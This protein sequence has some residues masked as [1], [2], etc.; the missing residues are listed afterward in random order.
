MRFDIYFTEQAEEE[1]SHIKFNPLY[2]G[3]HKQIKKTLIYLSENPRHKS[4]N[5]HKH[6]EKSKEYDF[7]VFEAYAQNNTPGAY[8]IFFCYLKNKSITILTISPHP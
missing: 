4:L 2:K 1:Y 8:R 5:T 6:Y 7:E 3:L